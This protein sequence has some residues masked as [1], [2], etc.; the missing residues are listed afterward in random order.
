MARR[1]Y[2]GNTQPTT[3][4]SPITNVDT[5]LTVVSGTNY[6][7]GTAGPAILTLDAGVA[8]EEKV[9]YT[10]RTGNIF[11]GLTRGYDGTTAVL[12][13]AGASVRHSFSA[14]DANEANAHVNVTTQ[15]DHTQYA[16]RGQGLAANVGVA[17]RAGRFYIATD[18]EDLYTDDGSA[19]HRILSKTSA[20]A[21]YVAAGSVI[22]RVSSF[23]YGG[24]S[25]VNGAL[26][27]QGIGAAGDFVGKATKVIASGTVSLTETAAGG[28]ATVHMELSID[29]GTTWSSGSDVN[30]Q[31]DTSLGRQTVTAAHVLTGTPTSQVQMRLRVTR[32]IGTQLNLDGGHM[33]GH[34][35][36]P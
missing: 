11:S 2:A 22:N 3:L 33:V 18:S 14:L 8:G 4:A 5:S 19:V 6:P 1:S 9:L 28:V 26:A 12:H 35:M 21:A 30:V 13:S 10:T 23:G 36:T 34:A 32:T 27:A 31:T 16:K 24:A 17:S 15:D 20:D 25:N 7:D 29:G